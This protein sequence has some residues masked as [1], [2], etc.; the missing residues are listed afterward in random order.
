MA[1]AA[2]LGMVRKHRRLVW[3]VM[4]G[5]REGGK[6]REEVAEE[7]GYSEGVGEQLPALSTPSGRS[8]GSKLK[9]V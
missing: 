6:E 5:G 3:S 7:G 9:V 2:T 8:N 1:A 4:E